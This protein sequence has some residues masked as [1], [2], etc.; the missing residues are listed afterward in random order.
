[1]GLWMTKQN[2]K[3]DGSLAAVSPV[4]RKVSARQNTQVTLNKMRH[5]TLTARQMITN[6][7]GAW[8]D[9]NGIHKQKGEVDRPIN[10]D[11]RIQTAVCKKRNEKHERQRNMKTV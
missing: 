2:N 5:K 9:D 10:L 4:N 1:M 7:I 11:V 8:Q 6:N 3:Q